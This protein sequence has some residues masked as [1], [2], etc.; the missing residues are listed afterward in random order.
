MEVNKSFWNKLNRELGKTLQQQL[1]DE[2]G[3]RALRFSK[4]RFIQKNWVDTTPK[5]WEPRKRKTNGSLLVKSGRLKRSIRIIRKT[6]TSVTIGTDTPYAR[7]H[8]EGGKINETVQV[9]EHYRNR[10]A[11]Q[12]RGNGKIKVKAHS[13]KVNYTIPKRQFIGTSRA[14]TRKIKRKMDILA[15]NITKKYQ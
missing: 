9:R 4:Q 5:A 2:A 11:R 13:R 14:L 7:I 6:A 10:S 1:I 12:K 15:K 8:N 3:T